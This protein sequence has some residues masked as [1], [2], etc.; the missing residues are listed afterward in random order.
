MPL[1][2]PICIL[3]VEIDGDQVETLSLYDGEKPQD[4]VLNFGKQFN[5]TDNA[6]KRLLKQILAQLQ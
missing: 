5:L 2:E 6:M 3:K 1:R 4:V